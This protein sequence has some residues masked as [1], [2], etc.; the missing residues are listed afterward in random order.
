MK[1]IKKIAQ[2]LEGKPRQVIAK[3]CLA[4]FLISFLVGFSS[5]LVFRELRLNR[6]ITKQEVQK[7]EEEK[8]LNTLFEKFSQTKPFQQKK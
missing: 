8:R 5:G 7:I 3:I 6:L 4:S 1:K 2:E